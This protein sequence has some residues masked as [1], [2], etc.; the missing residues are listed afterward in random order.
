MVFYHSNIKVAIAEVEE[1]EVWC[2]SVFPRN[3]RE[4]LARSL[5]NTAA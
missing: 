2:E 1:L 5:Y 4:A 3:F